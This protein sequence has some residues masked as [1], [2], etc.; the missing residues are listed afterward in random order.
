NGSPYKNDDKNIFDVKSYSGGIGYRF[1]LFY[2]DLAYQRTETTNTFS[3]YELND[4]S[5]PIATAK[6][7]KN[8]I[9]MTVGVKF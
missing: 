1:N 2:V 9:F 6:V 8:N 4:F 7:A 5:E 3:P